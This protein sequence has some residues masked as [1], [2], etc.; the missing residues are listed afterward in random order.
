MML[1]FLSCSMYMY[2]FFLGGG[3][4]GGVLYLA[5]VA[6]SIDCFHALLDPFSHVAP[7][8]NSF[9]LRQLH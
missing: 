6:F 9:F 2:F 5:K 7:R 3:G 4:W 8:N 1:I